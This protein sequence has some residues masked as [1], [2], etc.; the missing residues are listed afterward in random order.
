MKPNSNA[1]S[2]KVSSL[3]H[4]SVWRKVELWGTAGFLHLEEENS[5]MQKTINLCMKINNKFSVTCL[6]PTVNKFGGHS[7]QVWGQQ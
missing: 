3:W 1:F 4:H 2:K 6:G 7:I 5:G